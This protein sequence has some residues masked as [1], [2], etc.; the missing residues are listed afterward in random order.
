[1]LTR[2]LIALFLAPISCTTAPPATEPVTNAKLANT[3]SKSP[4]ST[5][6]EP[7]MFDCQAETGAPHSKI[8]IIKYDPFAEEKPSENTKDNQD[9]DSDGEETVQFDINDGAE[10]TIGTCMIIPNQPTR[11]QSDD[12][13]FR[14]LWTGKLDP[15]GRQIVNVEEKWIIRNK[16]FRVNCISK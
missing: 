10:T 5:E 16:K 13:S 4:D 2:A 3:T 1:M 11:C 12:G 7:M 6:S 14:M 15:A 8:Q 9:A